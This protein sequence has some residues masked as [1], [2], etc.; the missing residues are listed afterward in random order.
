MDHLNDGV[1]SASLF[2]HQAGPGSA[3]LHF[4]GGVGAVAHLL[5]QPLNMKMIELARGSPSWQK[6]TR[7]AL[8]RLRQ[9]QKSIAHGGGAKP[10]VSGDQIFP[11]RRPADT[12]RLGGIGADIGASLLLRHAHTHEYTLLLLRRTKLGIVNGR[13]H[14]F[15][16][17][18]RQLRFG[19]QGCHAG[20][21]HGDGASMPTFILDGHH[22]QRGT[23]HLCSR[24]LPGPFHFKPGQAMDVMLHRGAHQVVPPRMKHHFVAPV[25]IAVIGVQHRLIL[26]GFKSPAL[27]FLLAKDPA[28]IAKLLVRPLSACLCYRLRECLVA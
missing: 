11:G 17:L 7:E 4:A 8:G 19:P 3:E 16:P 21:R 12:F 10:F 9:D 28:Q 23:D 14:L 13:K 24:P 22:H 15:F 2:A 20:K 25:A 5:L 6:K 26:I 18:T 1:N 27:G